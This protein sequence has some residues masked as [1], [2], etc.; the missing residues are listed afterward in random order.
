LSQ[1]KE[2]KQNKICPQKFCPQK[3]RPEFSISLIC[4][5]TA[6]YSFEEI[7]PFKES[8]NPAIWLPGLIKQYPVSLI[9]VYS[10]TQSGDETGIT[11][12]N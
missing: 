12:L 9:T 2:T 6:A 8:K 11:G 4:F 10:Y 3:I 1:K 7:K 5:S